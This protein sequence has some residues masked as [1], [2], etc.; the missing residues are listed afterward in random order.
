MARLSI[1][2]A[3]IV[4][5]RGAAPLAAHSLGTSLVIVGID[6]VPI[7]NV[8]AIAGATVLT[9]STPF[10]RAAGSRIG[11]FTRRS[12]IAVTAPSIVWGPRVA[13]VFPVFLEAWIVH[14]LDS[15][16]FEISRVIA[17]A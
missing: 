17:A 2:P 15:R 9:W 16:H 8:L 10:E 11:W 14:S 3:G 7:I 4:A 12:A 1:V 6:I 5:A 13:A